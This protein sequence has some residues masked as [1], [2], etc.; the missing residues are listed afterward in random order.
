M[1]KIIAHRK[2]LFAL[3]ES[4]ISFSTI[5]QCTG[6][7]D[8]W[9]L[10]VDAKKIHDV[11]SNTKY[12]S[13]EWK[14]LVFGEPF[15]NYWLYRFGATY[16]IFFQNISTRIEDGH[17]VD[18]WARDSNTEERFAV[19]HK[20]FGYNNT[21]L[22]EHTSGI[23][24]AA[25]RYGDRPMVVT[26]AHEISLAVKEDIV[27]TR[28]VVVTRDHIEPLVKNQTFW[29]EFQ[30]YLFLNYNEYKK[31]QKDAEIEAQKRATRPLEDWQKVDMGI[32]LS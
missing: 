13:D 8:Y 12:S 24:W 26:T 32:L 1:T 20:F 22:R 6:L 23:A 29:L 18:A 3:E 16:G 2:E 9:R 17:G 5:G 21:V 4:T 19:N 10:V 7:V 31:I 14:G 11:I 15:L 28:G 27:A 30:E 25:L